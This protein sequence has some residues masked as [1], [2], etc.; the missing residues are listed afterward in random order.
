M[1][2]AVER[3]LMEC[4]MLGLTKQSVLFLFFAP[5]MGAQMARDSFA[6]YLCILS[7]DYYPLRV[8]AA[9]TAVITRA[10]VTRCQLKVDLAV[11][12]ENG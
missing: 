1:E 7:V 9:D 4:S 12:K 10:R 6:L 11:V 2:A 3:C 8:I 5:T